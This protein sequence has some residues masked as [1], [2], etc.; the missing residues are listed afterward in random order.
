L[1]Q[2]EVQQDVA[3]ESIF[4][5]EQW[6]KIKELKQDRRAQV[7]E[8]IARAPWKK[9]KK[10]AGE[11]ELEQ[12]Q[13][14]VQ[15]QVAGE[16]EQVAR[17]QELVQQ[18]VAGEQEQVAGTGEQELEQ[19]QEELPPEQEQHWTVTMQSIVSPRKHV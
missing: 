4:F 7:A 2:A 18:Q 1:F 15:Q 14:L 5:L 16:Q 17:E 9:A 13:E 6:M 10:A 12:Q 8:A 19:Q 11:Q 3:E